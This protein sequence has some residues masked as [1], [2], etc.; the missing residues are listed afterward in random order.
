MTK[1]ELLEDLQFSSVGG[2]YNLFWQNFDCLSPDNRC[3]GLF[4]FATTQVKGEI[5]FVAGQGGMT[6][7]KILNHRLFKKAKNDYILAIV[8]TD[9]IRLMGNCEVRVRKDGYVILKE[10]TTDRKGNREY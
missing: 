4:D 9:H 5:R 10:F 2:S 6:K 3:I 7:E 8:F 1:K